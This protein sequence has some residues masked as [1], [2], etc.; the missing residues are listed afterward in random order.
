M[1]VED[2]FVST[3][4]EGTLIWHLHLLPK[5][6]RMLSLGYSPGA[7]I[8][9]SCTPSAREQRTDTEVSQACSSPH[10]P[11]L[12]SP[13]P[14]SVSIE[15]YACAHISR[16]V[17]MARFFLS[18]YLSNCSVQIRYGFPSCLASLM[19]QDD[20]CVSSG[21]V[22]RTLHCSS[23]GIWCWGKTSQK[24]CVPSPATCQ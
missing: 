2:A 12:D 8:R 23:S 16:E 13:L 9:Q 14:V 10:S 24:L 5:K 21:Q 20:S 15:V 3:V 6:L 18:P 19:I 4:L 22:N 17:V 7:N 1:V 11:I